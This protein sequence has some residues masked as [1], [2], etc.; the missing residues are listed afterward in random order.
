MKKIIY[1]ILFLLN[2]FLVFSQQEVIDKLINPLQDNSLYREKVFIHT[3]KTGYF[4]NENIWFSVYVSKDHDNT[5]SEYTSN[6]QVNLLNVEGEVIDSKKVFIKNGKGEGNFS[7]KSSLSSGTYYINGFTNYMKNFGIE[8]QYIQELE[9][10]NP[11]IKNQNISESSNVV[12]DIQ[13]HPESGYLLED[14]ENSLGIKVLGNGKGIP[15]EGI[16]KNSKGEFVSEF[17]GNFLGFAKCVF[18]YKI[19]ETYYVEIDVNGTKQKIDVPKPQKKGVIFSLD[20]SDEEVLKIVLNTNINFLESTQNKELILLFHRKNNILDAVTLTLNNKTQTSQELY[21]NK[22]KFLYGVN[23][24]TLF[25]NLQPIAQRKFFV[26]DNE[27]QTAIVIEKLNKVNDSISYKIK[28][29]DANGDNVKSNLSVSTLPLDSKLFDQKQHI[30]SAFL[31]SPYIKGNIENPS[32]Y[33]DIDNENNNTFL[34]L[35]LLNQGWMKYDLSTMINQ[36]NPEEKYQFQNGFTVT[37]KTNKIPKGYDVVL[38]SKQNSIITISKLD[39]ENNFMFDNIYAYKHDTVKVAYLK[40]NK[41]LLKPNKISFN[42]PNVSNTDFNIQAQNISRNNAI[43][44]NQKE[45]KIISSTSA[46]RLEEVVLKD[47]KRKRKETYFDQEDNIAEK[48]KE[49]AASFYKNKKVTKEME[50]TFAT[51]Y[52]FFR[53]LGFVKVS[54][55]GNVFLSLRNVSGSLFSG[56]SG[57]NPDGTYPP[58]VY[59]DNSSIMASNFETVQKDLYGR[60]ISTVNTGGRKQSNGSFSSNVTNQGIEV[61]KNLEMKEVDEILINRT[62]AGGGITGMGGTIKIYRKKGDHKYFEK[63]KTP[64]YKNLVLLTGYDKAEKYYKP[65]YTIDVSTIFDWTE[66]DW[67]S[68]II[69]DEK[70]EVIIKIPANKMNEKYQLIINGFSENGLL[71]NYI[72]KDEESK[73]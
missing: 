50:E 31:L 39:K 56:V 28:T 21:F 66:I 46:E 37:G 47:V 8:N 58:K 43:N 10:I 71:F 35:L 7:I 60:T 61:L 49:I 65:Y 51:V 25:E 33:F 5:P 22:S 42:S 63:S 67:K 69:T 15:F 55:H 41:P 40:K 72:Y 24:V 3:N 9:I 32:Y 53:F 36:L 30:E 73:F 2:S 23:T 62:G 38:L 16:L 11:K 48:R 6:L 12:Y 70:G 18:Q 13:L 20:N 45:E 34:D 54:T 52:D 29:I 27:K 4:V 68:T 14:A 44:S 17:S 19:D 1:S 64:L 26:E 57:L 59:L